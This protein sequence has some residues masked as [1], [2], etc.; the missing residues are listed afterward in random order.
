MAT[1]LMT[2]D[3]GAY[4]RNQQMLEEDARLFPFIALEAERTLDAI[5]HVD[6]QVVPLKMRG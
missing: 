5:A 4:N 2:F 1:I 3:S 6:S